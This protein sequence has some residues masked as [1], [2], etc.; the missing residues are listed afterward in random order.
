MSW[1]CGSARACPSPRVE[2]V[3]ISTDPDLEARYHRRIPVFALGEDES[4]LITTQRQVRA[5]LDRALAGS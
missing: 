3:D 4:D 2:R 1:P 5:L